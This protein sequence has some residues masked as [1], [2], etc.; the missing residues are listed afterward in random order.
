MSLVYERSSK[1]FIKHVASTNMPDTIARSILLSA[2]YAEIENLRFPIALLFTKYH[3]IHNAAICSGQL[4]TQKKKPVSTR[5]S[6]IK[7]TRK[8]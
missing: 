4:E 7:K 3:A 6:M 1:F 5:I 8:T 2:S